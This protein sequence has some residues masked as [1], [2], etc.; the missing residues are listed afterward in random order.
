[1][2]KSQQK[3]LDVMW[4]LSRLWKELED[5]K[6]VPDDTVPVPFEDHIKL[7]VQTV[8][9]LS[10]A[11][12]SILYS[13]G[14][15]ILKTL[16][17]DPK[18]AKNILKVKAD[19]LQNSDQNLFGKKF[20]SHVVETELPKKRTLEVLSIGN[21]CGP[22]AAKIPF[23]TDPSPNS[24]KPYGG[25]RFYYGKKPSNR[26]RHNKQ[27]VANKATNEAVAS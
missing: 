25:G 2:E 3:T 16:M 7:I 1:M 27:M 8:L 4:P 23:Q 13:R 5:I 6:N 11:S 12:N 18:K 15:Q 10:Q 26:D 22:P 14:L 19:L 24:N 17:K 21:R 9:L 20:R